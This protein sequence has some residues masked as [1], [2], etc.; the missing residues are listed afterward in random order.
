MG[1]KHEHHGG[2]W[3]VAYADFVTAMMAFFMVLWL[4]SQDAKVKEAVE[5]SFRNPF[6]TLTK[7]ATGIVPNEE[8]QAVKSTAGNFDSASAV[9]LTMLRRLNQDLLNSLKA[10]DFEDEESGVLNLKDNGLRVSIFDKTQKPIF[11]G[12]TEE[13]TEYGTWVFTTLAWQIARYPMFH[14]ELEGHTEELNIPSGTNYDKWQLTAGRANTAR[15]LLEKHGVKKNQIVRVT[16]FADT[17]PIVGSAPD[18]ENNRRVEVKLSVDAGN[19]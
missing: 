19:R 14:I 16:G 12:H 9:E 8:M 10:P 3:K 11:K 18:A 17:R 1:K 5:R 4:T 2:A 6:S 13:F 7:Q 15:K